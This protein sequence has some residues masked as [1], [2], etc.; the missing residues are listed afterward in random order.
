M[1]VC[2]WMD[3]ASLTGQT[4]PSLEETGRDLWDAATYASYVRAYAVR[5]LLFEQCEYVVETS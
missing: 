2:V 4:C 3:S 5:F 1:H